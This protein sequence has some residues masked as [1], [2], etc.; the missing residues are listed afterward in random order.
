MRGASNGGIFLSIPLPSSVPS[1]ELLPVGSWTSL[2]GPWRGFRACFTSNLLKRT[3]FSLRDCLHR[4]LGVCG[5]LVFLCISHMM[6]VP[7]ESPSLLL[8]LPGSMAVWTSTTFCASVAEFRSSSSF[9]LA[10]PIAEL[11]ANLVFYF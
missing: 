4:L 6:L 9:V 2:G 11:I 3:L 8:F 10:D 5:S 1:F 7:S